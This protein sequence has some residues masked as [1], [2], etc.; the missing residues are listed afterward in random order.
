ML[1]HTDFSMTIAVTGGTGFVGRHVLRL[2][3]Q[4]GRTVRAL[5]RDPAKLL[6]HPATTA[7]R[8]DLA[9]RQALAALCA[10]ASTVLHIA[11][12]VSGSADDLHEVNAAGTAA[13]LNA[14]DRAGVGRFVH[15]SSLAARQPELSPYGKSKAQAEEAV[16]AAARTIRTLIIRPP[17]VY[18]EGDTA[19]LP[20]LKTLTSS[21][22]LLPSRAGNR[23]SLIHAEDLSRVLV[24]AVDDG[25][26]G[27]REVDDGHGAYS[28][29]EVATVVRSLCGRPKRLVFLPR[30]IAMAVGHGADAVAKLTGKPGMISAGKMRELYHPDW[31]SRPPGWPRAQT[32]SLHEGMH[33]TLRDAMARGLLQHLPLADRS[34]TP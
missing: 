6:E 26:E 15:V 16:N 14:A 1:Q 29:G 17:A 2:L 20:L 32:I 30:P 7:V 28:W 9:D 34:P 11:G 31:V 12:A 3:Q 5:A 8:G 25:A 24:A 19:T 23:F 18:G 21:L 22:A 27:L 4:S 10:G 33:R 13:M